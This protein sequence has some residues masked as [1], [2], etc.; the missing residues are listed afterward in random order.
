MSSCDSTSKFKDVQPSVKNYH[1]P[2]EFLS[3][4]RKGNNVANMELLN[5]FYK[6]QRVMKEGVRHL[7]NEKKKRNF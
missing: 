7:L 6:K 5:E 4:D 2:K 3:C 1:S